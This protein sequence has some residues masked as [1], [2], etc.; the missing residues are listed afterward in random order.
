MVDSLRLSADLHATWHPSPP[1]R[2][3]AQF[4]A[5]KEACSKISASEMVSLKKAHREIQQCN[6]RLKVFFESAC[7]LRRRALPNAIVVPE[8]W[9]CLATFVAE[10]CHLLVH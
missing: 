6:Q 1:C 7:Q 3:V 9:Q 5:A 2:V 4:F 10:Q 8:L